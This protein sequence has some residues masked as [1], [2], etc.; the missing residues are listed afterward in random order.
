MYKNNKSATV[1]GLILIQ[2]ALSEQVSVC[3]VT[4]HHQATRNSS[5]NK[6]KILQVK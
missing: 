4:S 1:E 5:E 3:L 2:V 6:I